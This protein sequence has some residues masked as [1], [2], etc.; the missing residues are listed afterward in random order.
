MLLWVLRKDSVSFGL[1]FAYLSLL[2][3]QHVPGAYVQLADERFIGHRHEIEIG[4]RLTAI[5][6]VCFLIGAWLARARTAEARVTSVQPTCMTRFEEDRPFWLFCFFGGMLFTFGLT[7]LRNLPSIGAIVYNGGVI[8]VLGVLLGLRA[9]IR[10]RDTTW[11]MVWGALLVAYPALILFAMG[12]LS[13]GA[14]AVIIV[15]CALAISGRRYWRVVIT[16]VLTVY[17]ALSLFSNYFQARDNIRDAVWSGASTERRLDAISKVFTEFKFFDG[18]DELVL[19]GF[20]LRL[21]QNY[22]IGLA[23]ENIDNG[24]VK[25]LY[26]ESITDAML[27]L[28]PRALWPGK[29][30]FG[31]SPEVV[32]NMTG[33]ELSP[34]TSWGVG[35]VME[36]YINF[37]VPGLIIGFLGLGWLL[38]RFDHRAA[39]AETRHDYGTTLLFFLPA[40]ALVQPLGS[41]VELSGSM[42]AAWLAAYLWKWV[43]AHWDHRD[44]G[45]PVVARDKPLS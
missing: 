23:S 5:G 29:T 27:A 1:P 19:V 35:N 20:D 4:I 32:S 45:E 12:F 41:M 22:F 37:G 15:V 11:I 3:L 9:A 16:T 43:W 18:T 40:V 26:G 6:V 10:K 2:L 38:G 36:F 33:L 14:Q 44:R 24:S 8:W 7:P 13:Y 17:L 31:G 25:F 42:G 34:N 21:N 30:V 39:L 28:V